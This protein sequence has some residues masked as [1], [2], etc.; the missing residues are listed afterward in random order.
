MGD[1]YVKNDIDKELNVKNS[2]TKM[3]IIIF[4]GFFIVFIVARYATDESFRYDIDTNLLKKE[5]SESKLNTIEI[6]SDYNP[7]VYAYDKYITV[8][9][10]N[11]LTEYTSDGKANTELDVNISVPL[12][13][14]S[15]R[16]LVM[17]EK[18]GQKIYLISGSNILWQNTIQGNISQINV[19]KNGYV[20][21]IVKN[22]IS[23]SVII[24]FDLNGKE[25]FRRYLSSTYPTCTAISTNNNYLA[26]GEVDYSGT[27]IKSY[28]EILSVEIAQKDPQNSIIYT[29]ESENGEIITNID[30]KNKTD[31]ICMFNNYI[32]KVTPDSNERIYDITNNDVFVDINLKDSFAIIDKQSSGLF[33]YEYEVKI[34]NP[35]SSSESL[36]ILNS[37][38]PK[39]MLVSGNQMALNLGNEVQIVNSNG[40]LLKKYTSSKQ[41]NNI[42]LGNSI[43]GIV[44]KNKIEIIGL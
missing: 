13:A 12:T 37:D 3:L 40:W 26:I 30:Y 9:S 19:N 5:V 10:K 21:V 24:Y 4:V 16:Y 42:V 35:N 34:K 18:N 31:A 15:E 14:S 11:K 6:N 25:V 43:A 1:K 7:Y 8:L 29:Y 39:S 38:L 20:S 2:I 27:I 23:K 22:N 33:S 17:A 36:Y 28:V 32:Q 44:Y 41:V